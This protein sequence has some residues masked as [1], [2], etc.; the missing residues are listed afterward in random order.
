MRRYVDAAERASQRL[1]EF[2]SR[3]PPG[4]QGASGRATARRDRRRRPS[5]GVVVEASILARLLGI[6]LLTLDATVVLVPA[7]VTAPPTPR[8]EPACARS[9]QSSGLPLRAART[10]T[11]R[12][13]RRS[14]NASTRAQSFSPRPDGTAHLFT[15][16]FPLNREHEPQGPSRGTRERERWPQRRHGRW[17]TRRVESWSYLARRSARPRPLAPK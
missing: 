15:P 6:R 17:R 11:G 9:R 16:R 4:G 3:H 10:P 2:S 7:D 12:L 5:D 8:Y 1:E 13:G 14:S